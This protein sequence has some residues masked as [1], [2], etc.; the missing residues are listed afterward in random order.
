[1]LSS[2]PD[3]FIDSSTVLGFSVCEKQDGLF[4]RWEGNDETSVVA[5]TDA[6]IAQV[7]AYVDQNLPVWHLQ[8]LRRVRNE[9]LAETDWMANSDVTMSDAWRTY[10]QALRDLPANTTDPANPVWPTKPS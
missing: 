3:L 6:E 1:M 2:K 8:E 10:R 4:Y 5:L 7:Q 9:K